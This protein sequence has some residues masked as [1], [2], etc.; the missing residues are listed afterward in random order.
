MCQEIIVNCE[1]FVDSVKT[2]CSIYRINRKILL[3]ELKQINMDEVYKD[4]DSG[5]EIHFYICRKLGVRPC[6]IAKIIWFH[7]SKSLSLDNYF[8]KGILPTNEVLGLLKD[9]CYNLIQE[10]FSKNEWNIIWEKAIETLP[11]NDRI[12]FEMFPPDFGPNGMLVKDV[13][14]YPAGSTGFFF[15]RPEIVEGILCVIDKKY[16]TNMMGKFLEKGQSCVVT[17]IADVDRSIEYITSPILFYVYNKLHKL[18]VGPDCNTNYDAK[19]K[20]IEP[21][22]ILTVET[23]AFENGKAILQNVVNK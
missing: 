12:K 13:G 19:N 4:A 14:L 18:Q 3:S 6:H 23:I 8:V 16:N 11:S 7:F 15:D 22:R 10:K 1:S 9:D 2:L 20:A 17:F 5:E 21:C